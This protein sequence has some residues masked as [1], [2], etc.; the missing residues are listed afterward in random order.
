MG[1]WVTAASAKTQTT[2]LLVCAT[3]SMADRTED[4]TSYVLAG[5]PLLEATSHQLPVLYLLY[6][7]TELQ[8]SEL[9]RRNCSKYR[10]YLVFQKE[11]KKDRIC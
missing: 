7:Y 10:T 8:P 3:T 1:R 5:T 9:P 6:K 11:K 4:A 2:P